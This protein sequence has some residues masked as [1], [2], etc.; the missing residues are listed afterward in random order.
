MRRYIK[1]A[2]NGVSPKTIAE[3]E[4]L[5]A[6]EKQG[7]LQQIEGDRLNAAKWVR[8][9]AL[10]AAYYERVIP[11]LMREYSSLRDAAGKKAKAL[12][13]DPA[14]PNAEPGGGGDD[15]ESYKA[16]EIPAF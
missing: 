10:R 4:S 13:P 3:L 9:M 1:F 2:A 12:P 15:F 6:S 16:G 14:K 5:P 11:S 7:R 8:Q